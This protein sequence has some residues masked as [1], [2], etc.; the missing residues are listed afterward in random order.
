[1]TTTDINDVHGPAQTGTFS[2]PVQTVTFTTPE[3]PQNLRDQIR[4]IWVRVV[5]SELDRTDRQKQLDKQLTEIASQIRDIGARVF[6]LEAATL[7]AV[8]IS[9]AAVMLGVGLMLWIVVMR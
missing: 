4:E 2:G 6:R 1:V 9:T 5:E 3:P 8:V 7:A